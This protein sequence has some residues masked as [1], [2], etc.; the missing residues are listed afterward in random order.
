MATVLAP[1]SHTII[2]DLARVAVS[3]EG[4]P[5]AELTQHELGYGTVLE[6]L[7]EELQRHCMLLTMQTPANTNA[8]LPAGRL[9][10]VNAW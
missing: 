1:G 9:V 7:Q 3:S 5:L 8:V 4:Q 6:T 2:I 10:P